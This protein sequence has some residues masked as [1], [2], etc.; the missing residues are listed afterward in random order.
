M[1]TKIIISTDIRYNTLLQIHILQYI[2]K[3]VNNIKGKKVKIF[4][5]K[6]I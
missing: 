6:Y 5:H 3:F 4:P 2:T 1:I